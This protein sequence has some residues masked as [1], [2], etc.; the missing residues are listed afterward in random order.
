M[1]N[2]VPCT[3]RRPKALTRPIGVRLPSQVRA[4]AEQLAVSRNISLSQLGREAIAAAVQEAAYA[5]AEAR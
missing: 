2:D 3:Y 1:S 5:V 4:A